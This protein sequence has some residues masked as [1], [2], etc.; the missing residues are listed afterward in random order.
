MP[1]ARAAASELALRAAATLVAAAG[2]RSIIA[3]EH[4]QRLLREAAFLLVFG[5][6][7]GIRTELLDRLST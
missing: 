1:T 5:S 7:P 2:A 3:G 6:R 4:P